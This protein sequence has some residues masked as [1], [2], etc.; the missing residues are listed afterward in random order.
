MLEGDAARARPLFERSIE[1][2]RQLG[3][4]TGI[5]L[6]LQGL[7]F[8]RPP[9]GG[10]EARMQI[11]ESLG[12][13]RGLGDRRNV[14]KVLVVA[15]EINVELGE[16]EAAADQLAEALTLFVEFGDRWFWG[17]TLETAAQLAVSVGEPERAAR[18]FGAADAVW[19]TIGAPLP[20]K[21]RDR[22]DHVLAEVRSR[23]GDARFEAL[24]DE[25][26]SLP[27]GATIELV[28]PV[29]TRAGVDVPGGAHRARGRGAG[30]GRRRPHRRAG[31]GTSRRQ[32]P[33]GARPSP[34]DLS[35]A[36]RANA[37]RCH[38]IRRRA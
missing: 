25:G 1:L 14:T 16:L 13:L 28:Q 38:A 7:A 26:R 23:L 36:R 12:I 20:R 10:P 15:A 6:A 5:A 11:E 22:H 31:G 8:S 30:A 33:H 2:F 9:G 37:K 21:L 32:H 34:L 35:Q 17:W 27:V 4:S 24:R 18:L 3:D 19:E 29:A